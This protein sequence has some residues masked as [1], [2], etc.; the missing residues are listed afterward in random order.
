MQKI[1][2]SR[3]ELWEQ[4]DRPALKALPAHRY[5]LAEWKVCRVNIDYHVE[6]DRHPYSVPYQLA[7]RAG[8]GALHRHDRRDL[9]QGPPPGV[10]PAPLRPP[11]LDPGRAHAELAPGARG[12]DA[13]A[14]DPLGGE[15]RTGHRPGG[16][17]DP[18]EPAPPRAGL[19]RLPGADAAGQALRRRAPRGRLRARRAP[20]L[21]QLPHGQ[22]HPRLG[23]GPHCHREGRTGQGGHAHPRQHPRRRPTTPRHKEHEC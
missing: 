6:V 20:A 18:E 16:G 21:L 14:A 2:K 15:D 4:L 1:G 8:G 10:P 5:E 11:A 12:V 17:R 23:P 22:E 7:R 3:R 13:F 19:P 9:L